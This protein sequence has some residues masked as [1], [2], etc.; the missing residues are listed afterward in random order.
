MPCPMIA[1]LHELTEAAK[2]NLRDALTQLSLPWL[3]GIPWLCIT[4]EIDEV[5]VACWGRDSDAGVEVLALHP[6]T[7][8]WQPAVLRVI[9]QHELLHRAGYAAGWHLPETL[10]ANLA[11]DIVINHILRSEDADA[12]EECRTV[13]YANSDGPV[14]LAAGPWARV[15]PQWVELHAGI[16]R[17]TKPPSPADIYAALLKAMPSL[18]VNVLT[19][20]PFG[21]SPRGSRFAPRQTAPGIDQS[22][23]NAA[24][25]MADR[26]L[27]S[28]V[29]RGWGHSDLPFITEQISPCDKVSAEQV[30]AL[31]A[32]MET[33]RLALSLARP[34]LGHEATHCKDEWICRQPTRTT[35][36]LMAAGIVPD[37]LP[38]YTNNTPRA[39]LPEIRVYVDVSGSLLEDLDLV[40]AVIRAVR[41]VLPATVSVFSDE[42]ADVAT[43]QLASGNCPRGFGTN[44]GAVMTHFCKC[45]ESAALMITDGYGGLDIGHWQA[46]LAQSRKRLY[47]AFI[48]TEAQPPLTS[49]AT[50]WARVERPRARG[51]SLHTPSSTHTRRRIT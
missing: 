6:R 1:Y 4:D 16:W 2:A 33:R 29:Q 49:L 25:R 24:Q 5:T 18:E 28:A 48:S 31:L 34:L 9:L 8:E 22:L 27:E 30:R 21:T 35:Q 17:S 23:R 15:S 43:A 7:L 14:L 32:R 11:L 39:E 36:V 45:S 44:F 26:S 42:V 3:D 50:D 41:D 38:W 40:L 51:A 19:T 13:A 37:L 20:N 46:Q 10:V 47:A 12:F